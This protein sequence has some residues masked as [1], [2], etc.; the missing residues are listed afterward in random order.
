[1]PAGNGREKRKGRSLDLLSAIKK[2]ILTVKAAFLCLAHA[3]IIAMAKVNDDSNF[4]LYSN[5]RC[6]KEPVLELLKASGVD[7]SNGGGL[8]NFNSFRST[9]RITKLLCLTD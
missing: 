5:G 7:L 9:F 4:K 3:L 1:M 2:S 8:K 6:L